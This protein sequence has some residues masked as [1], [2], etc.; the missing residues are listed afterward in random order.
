[1]IPGIKLATSIALLTCAV[2]ATRL[3]L[4]PLA[5]II[6]AAMVVHGCLGRQL[7]RMLRAAIPIALFVAAVAA[8]QWFHG[9]VDWL[10]PLRTVAVFLLSTL[11]MRLAPWDWFAAHLSPRSKLYL[12]GLFLLFVRHFSEILVAEPQRTLQARA[13]CAPSLFRAGG[14]SS[15]AS[16][17]A[18]IFRRTLRRA[19]HFYAAQ[20]LNGIVQ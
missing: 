19:E 13:M 1:L 11:A 17:L 18:A 3:P 15:L 5:A 4:G 16:A 6:A 14:F 8:L 2:A 12:P 7:R 10:L 9:K 20:L